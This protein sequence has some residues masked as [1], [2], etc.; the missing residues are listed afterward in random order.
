MERIGLKSKF[1]SIFASNSSKNQK[2]NSNDFIDLEI[3]DTSTKKSASGTRINRSVKVKSRI[4]AEKMMTKNTAIVKKLITP[5][6]FSVAMKKEHNNESMELFLNKIVIENKKEDKKLFRN[7]TERSNVHLKRNELLSIRETV[8]DKQI[9]NYLNSVCID[10]NDCL[11]FGHEKNVIKKMFSDFANFKNL[12]G[13]SKVGENSN[14]GFVLNLR[15]EKMNYGVN[16]LLKSSK[17]RISDNLYYEY[18]AGTVFINK[19][20]DFFPCFTETYHLFR[21]RTLLSKGRIKSNNIEVSEYSDMVDLN[22]CDASV[23]KNTSLCIGNS[24]K[25]GVNFAILVQYINNPISIATYMKTNENDPQFLAKMICILLQ[26]YIPLS[27]LENEFTHYDLHTQNVLL[28]ELP[29]GKFVEM[30]YIDERNGTTVVFKTNYIVKIIDY[31]RCYFGNFGNRKFLSSSTI[32]ESIYNSPSCY[33]QGLENVGYNFFEYKQNAENFYISS[34]MKNISHDLRLASMMT[35]SSRKIDLLFDGLILYEGKY[36]TPSRISSGDE[37]INNVTDMCNFL[38]QK[39]IMRETY[40]SVNLNS[41][42]AGKIEVYITKHM[43]T[44]QM[45][46]IPEI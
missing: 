32:A 21:H 4:I 43:R 40:N 37:Y 36:G 34:T 27:Y 12:K 7:L 31:G 39:S 42:S 38:K 17:K 16:A 45:K 23:V 28:Y 18:L 11:I 35:K 10:S 5:K 44:K 25:N 13:V 33:E 20:N 6:T 41:L 8:F 46:F 1:M 24:C 19:I 30:E 29:N 2:N 26:V 15:F 22:I 9:V 3:G 14:N